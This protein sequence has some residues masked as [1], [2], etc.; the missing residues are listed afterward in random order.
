VLVSH[1]SGDEKSKTNLVSGGGADFLIHTRGLLP[2]SLRGRWGEGS[3]LGLSYM[4]T[5]SMQKGSTLKT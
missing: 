3:P 1:S 5:N 2:A 4:S